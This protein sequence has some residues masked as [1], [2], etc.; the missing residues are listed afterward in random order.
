MSQKEINSLSNARQRMERLNE[1]HARFCAHLSQSGTSQRF[2]DPLTIENLEISTVAFGK[3]LR[4]SPRIVRSGEREFAV[5]YT[6]AHHSGEEV[7]PIWRFYLVE[8]GYLL[9]DLENPQSRICDFNYQHIADSLLIPLNLATVESKLFAP[10]DRL[11][12]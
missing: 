3:P 11:D 7:T 4:A 5:E 10:A 9:A 6:F 2:P 8:D 1:T 12:R